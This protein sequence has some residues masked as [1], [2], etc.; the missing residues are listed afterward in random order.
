MF[1][2]KWVQRC[3]HW[4]NLNFLHQAFYQPLVNSFSWIIWEMRL[5]IGQTSRV[6][7]KRLRAWDKAWGTVRVP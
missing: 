5:F 1:P 4:Y 3:H 2:P 7:V 6:V